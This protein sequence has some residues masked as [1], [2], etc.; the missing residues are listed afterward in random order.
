MGRDTSQ[1]PSLRLVELPEIEHMFLNCKYLEKSYC[2]KLL[3][4][5]QAHKMFYVVHCCCYA[6]GYI[7]QIM[8]KGHVHVIVSQNLSEEILSKL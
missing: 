3:K 7:A 5:V 6:K 4:S 8:I 2:N 1:L